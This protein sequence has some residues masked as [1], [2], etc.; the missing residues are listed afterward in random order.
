MLLKR[1]MPCL[2]YDGKGL[3]KTIKF[4]NPGYIGDPIN[5][6]KIYNEK[7][8]D[9]L[10]LLDIYCTKEKRS[11]DFAKLATFTSEC[12]MPFSYGGGVSS[13]DD[14]HNLFQIGIEKV[15][16][17]SLLFTNPLIV[18]EAVMKFG[19][20][21]IVASLDFKSSFLGKKKVHS[22]RGHNPRLPIIDFA[23]YL[24][25]EIG[26]GEIFVN[27]VDRDGTWEG[28]DTEVIK[29]IANAVNVPIIACGGAGTLEDVKHMLYEINT[30]AAAI[31]SMA[32][33][34]KKGMGVLINFPK[35]DEILMGENTV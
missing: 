32:V 1:I 23:R 20:Q 6:I 28:Y 19:S 26:V 25:N 4:K 14:F 13:I 7:E 15:V 21:S 29:S 16:V 31:G 34:Q 18:K 27:S 30:N 24:E 11:I 5:A 10:V 8:V 3:V 22:H 17:N 35:R 33:Y 2:L 12:F 9:E